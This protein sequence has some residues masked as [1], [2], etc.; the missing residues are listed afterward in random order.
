MSNPYDRFTDRARKVMAL[1]NQEAQRWGHEYISPE[2]IL[3]SIIKE[4]HGL[5]VKILQMIYPD[6]NSIYVAVGKLMSPTGSVVLEPMRKTPQAKLVVDTAVD[7]SNRME[8]KAVGTEHLLFGIAMS[9]SSAGALLGMDG[10]TPDKIVGWIKTMKT[11][12]TKEH[13]AEPSA[14]EPDLRDLFAMHA[15]TG[16]LVAIG[17]TGKG[18]NPASQYLSE[19]SYKLADAMLAARKKH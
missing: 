19:S 15:L 8:C 13:P 17:G 4:G 2:H 6:P 9:D 12:S 11:E 1:A 5:A 18:H 7:L 16:L 14:Q 3:L 10:L